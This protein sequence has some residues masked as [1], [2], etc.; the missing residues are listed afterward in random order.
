MNLRALLKRLLA[1]LGGVLLL[2]SLV[3]LTGAKRYA[4]APE[5]RTPLSLHGFTLV[6]YHDLDRR[7]GFK[8]AMQ[9]VA[10]RWYLYVAHMWQPGWTVLDVTEPAHPVARAFVEGPPNTMTLQVQVAGGRMVTGLERPLT[11]LIADIPWQGKAWILW[12]ELTTFKRAPWKTSREGIWIWDVTDPVRPRRVGEWASG[13]SGTHR[14]FYDGGRFVH[15]A[16]TLPG[17]RG[18]IYVVLDIHDPARPVEVSRWFL[19]EQDMTSGI[20][21]LRTGYYLHGPVHVEGD[22]AYLPYGI[23]GLVILDISDVRR[24]ALV[25]R[26]ALPADLGSA[27]GVHSVVPIP[28]RKLAV[29]NSEPLGERCPGADGR[30]YAAIVDIADEAAPRIV[31]FLPEP[32]PPPG[33]S[34]ATFCDRGGRFGTHNQHHPQHQPH[35]FASD[36]LVF[37]TYFNAGLRLYDIADAAHPRE[38]AHF[39]PPDPAERLGILPTELVVQTEDV[40]V[41]ARGYAYVSDKNQGIHIVRPTLE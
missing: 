35:L 11:E 15:L 16:T 20:E 32:H 33:S 34:F 29:I 17:Y 37:M 4:G 22:R 5:A 18:H 38:I 31:S 28:G 3:V 12:D 7:P 9:V 6:G 40:L 39:L 2:L 36:T 8:M 41:D 21:P 10:G 1:T 19:P 30:N 23:G 25:G 27:I 14:N 24:P 13:A 26:L